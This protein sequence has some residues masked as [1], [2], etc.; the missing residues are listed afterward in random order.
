MSDYSPIENAIYGQFISAAEAVIDF[1]FNIDKSIENESTKRLLT[2]QKEIKRLYRAANMTLKMKAK[3]YT[4][5]YKKAIDDLNTQI[6][7]FMTKPEY[8][9]DLKDKV[10]QANKILDEYDR[11]LI[12]MDIITESARGVTG[13]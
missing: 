4:D 2:A 12:E 7:E 11:L 5:D 10:F 8:I 13:Q 9:E 3:R 1:E 6:Q